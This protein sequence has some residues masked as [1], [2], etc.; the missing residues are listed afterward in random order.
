VSLASRDDLF[1]RTA[2]RGGDFVFDDSVAA[3]FD[4][5]LERSIPFYVE[6]QAMF[7]ELARRHWQPGTLVVDLGCSTG[8]T[9]VSIC[10]ELEDA[11]AVG[12][13]SAAPMLARAEEAL[14]RAGLRR[15]VELVEAD[16]DEGIG[17][18]G[19]RPASVVTICWTLQFLGVDNRQRLLREIHDLLVPG[20]A[21]VFAEKIVP[22]DR[23]TADLYTDLYHELKQRSGYSQTEIARKRTALE[24]VLVSSTV[25]ENLSFLQGAGFPSPSTFFQWYPFA[26]F[27]AVKSPA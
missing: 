7:A 6:Q 22:D 18:L 19:L 15:R 12:V 23:H 27:L 17:S 8:T 25:G 21:L 9:L 10:S 14:A 16:L 13:D 1:A 11:H 24:G 26:A 4:D 3:V 2:R 20:G 5:M